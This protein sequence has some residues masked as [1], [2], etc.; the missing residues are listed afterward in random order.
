MT[1][2]IREVENYFPDDA[3]QAA[4]VELAKY[5]GAEKE[6]V[7]NLTIPRWSHYFEAAEDHLKAQGEVVTGS[8]HVSRYSTWGESNKMNFVR[9]ALRAP[10][11]SIDRLQHEGGKQV[12]QIANW[13]AA[14]KAI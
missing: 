11:M 3:V 5:T 13:I 14:R 2:L 12:R 1:D 7:E 10:G 4:I 9:A 8:G 6:I